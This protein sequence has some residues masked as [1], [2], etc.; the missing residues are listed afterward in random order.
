MNEAGIPL[1]LSYDDV[2]L[3]PRRSGI[4]SRSD[5]DVSTR[6]SRNVRLAIPM[7]S[8]NMDTVTGSDMAIAMARAGGI[9]FIHRFLSIEEQVAEVARV[10]R[11]EALVISDPHTI[12]PGATL[13]E[14]QAVMRRLRVTSLMVDP[15][16]R[17][18]G[19]RAHR[20]RRDA[21]HR[22]ARDGRHAHDAAGATGDGRA[23]RRVPR[24]R[25]ASCATRASRSCPLVDEE[26]RLVGL[27][28]LRDILQRSERPE[29]TKDARGRLAVGAA[30]GVRGDFI[31]RAQALQDAGA[32]VVVLDIAHGHAEHA[33]RAIGEVREALGDGRGR[34]RR[35]RRHR[36]GRPRAGGSRG[37]RA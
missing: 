33:V 5:V 30:I 25:R 37:G 6:L 34:D 17:A 29:A 14:A 15:P 35:Q 32:D 1:A 19:R 27:I 12:A 31:E 4:A 23:R 9:G 2:L 8:A 3:A 24:R 13:V 7:V 16:R 10:K 11:A 26:D 21:A 28:T 18:P 20:A 36:R 22:P